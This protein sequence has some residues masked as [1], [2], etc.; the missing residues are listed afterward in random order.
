MTRSTRAVCAAAVLTASLL[1]GCGP[2]GPDSVGPFLD[3]VVPAGSSGSLVAAV[4]GGRVV[5]RGWGEA[6]REAGV[7]AGCDTV[8]DVMSMTKQ[9]TAA[10]VLK[11][12]TQGRLR[13]GDPIVRYFPQAPADKRHITVEQLLTH[14]SGLVASLGGDDE[15][16]S[17][18]DLVAEA[19]ATALRS[20]PGATYH[21][22]NTGYSLL[23]AIVEVASGTDYESYLAEHL[24]RPAGM[25]RTG[26]VLPDWQQRSIAVEYDASGE[27]LGRPVDRPWAEDG[28]YWNLRGNGGLLSTAGDLYRWHRALEE[29]VVLDE[30]ATRR[31][32]EPRVREEPGG[33]TFYGYGW[34]L[35]Q[36]GGLGVAWHNG[37]NGRSYGEIARGTDR[38]GFVFWVA[39]RVRDQ[40]AWDLE[41]TGPEITEGVLARLWGD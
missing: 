30:A 35:Q 34:V 37:G 10:A 6:D 39:N 27:P 23:A 36:V 21:Y 2:G 15:R 17:R 3:D 12:H 28:P 24:F 22:S 41:E 18:A 7:P 8:Y 9:F 14:T 40:D 5:C 29:H 13:V 11:L 20:E 26:Y 32:F 31:L 38:D 1:T 16:V 25:T 19:F 4:D 33:D